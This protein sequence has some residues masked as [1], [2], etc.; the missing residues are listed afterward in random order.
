[1]LVKYPSPQELGICVPASLKADRFCSG[2][3]HALRGGQ[4]NLAE[5][6]R[7]SFREGYRVGKLYLRELRRAQ[8]ILEYPMK[9]QVK[10][11]LLH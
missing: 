1:M 5:Q 10:L 2:F 6:L 7:L 11:K 9:A 3:K 8:G 4:I